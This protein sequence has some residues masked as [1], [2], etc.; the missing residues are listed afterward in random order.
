MMYKVDVPHKVQ[1]HLVAW[2]IFSLCNVRLIQQV[3]FKIF[4]PFNNTYIPPTPTSVPSYTIFQD[5]IGWRMI[6]RLTQ[7]YD[8]WTFLSQFISQLMGFI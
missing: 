2:G 3:S 1:N 7:K 6:H 8:I 5:L 4:F